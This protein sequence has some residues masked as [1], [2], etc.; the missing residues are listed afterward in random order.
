MALAEVP[1]LL[2]MCQK[3]KV[4]LLFVAGGVC[5]I[6]VDD[7]LSSIVVDVCVVM[8]VEITGRRFS[9]AHGYASTSTPSPKLV[10]MVFSSISPTLSSGT[11]AVLSI[12]CHALPTR[13][14]P[15]LSSS[16]L[17]KYSIIVMDVMEYSTIRRQTPKMREMAAY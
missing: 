2:D 16:P 6:F 10:M 11:V 14:P 4:A 7:S 15:S 9:R 8:V 12:N 5:S 3:R 1:P 17:S 13:S